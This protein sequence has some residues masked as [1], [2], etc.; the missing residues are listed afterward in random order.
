MPDGDQVAG[1]VEPR[2][3]ASGS[4]R[5]A[6]SARRG[7]LWSS[8]NATVGAIRRNSS[9]WSR[10]Q[11]ARKSHQRLLSK[12]RSKPQPASTEHLLERTAQ[13][14]RQQHRLWMSLPHP[15]DQLAP[16]VGRDL[17]GRAAAKAR[18]TELEEVQREIGE[19]VELV[20][21][22]ARARPGRVRR[23]RSI[24]RGVRGSLGLARTGASETAI[25]AVAKPVRA[26]RPPA[27]RRGPRAARSDRP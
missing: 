20:A 3:T 8:G 15:C 22:D 4:P 14:R 13:G 27:R 7:V 18:S 23:D 12:I 1:A 17:V 5:R 19:V 11:R 24:T 9:R 25:R 6:S 2:S 21:N 16:E 10:N 26:V